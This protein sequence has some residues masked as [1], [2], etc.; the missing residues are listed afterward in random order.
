MKPCAKKDN[1]GQA[2]DLSDSY[3]S[4]PKEGYKGVNE[5]VFDAVKMPE[6]NA[7][8]IDMGAELE[9]DFAK[10]SSEKSA[11]GEISVTPVEEE[12]D[13]WGPPSIGNDALTELQEAKDNEEREKA[14]WESELKDNDESDEYQELT[15]EQFAEYEAKI[16]SGDYIKPQKEESTFVEPPLDEDVDSEGP[17]N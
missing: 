3:K 14:D 4:F 2:Q 7:T 11:R 15:P 12:K 17:P 16:E 10:E 6:T 13:F 8:E 5:V 1:W 9:K